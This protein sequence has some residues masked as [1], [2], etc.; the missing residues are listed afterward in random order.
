MTEERIKNCQQ[1]S[2]EASSPPHSCTCQLH[3]PTRS[4]A[5]KTSTTWAEWTGGKIRPP[6]GKM[7]WT[8]SDMCT[9]VCMLAGEVRSDCRI[10]GDGDIWEKKWKRLQ[11]L[12]CFVDLI[13]AAEFPFHAICKSIIQKLTLTRLHYADLPKSDSNILKWK[14]SP[15]FFFLGLTQLSDYSQIMD[16]FHFSFQR[17]TNCM[18]EPIHIA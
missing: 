10:T 7:E 6:V 1:A 5:F 11:E 4:I 12:A 18:K 15:P 14:H 16:Y 9:F 13:Q 2:F 17:K 3:N 8:V